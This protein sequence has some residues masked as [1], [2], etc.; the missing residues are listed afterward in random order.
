MSSPR[1]PDV[2]PKA[3]FER[4][5]AMVYRRA[6]QLLGSHEDAEEAT[7]EVFIRV[8]RSGDGFEGK[9]RVTTWLYE[10]TTNYC[11]NQLR[12]RARRAELWQANGPTGDAPTGAGADD[13][14]AARQLLAR[15]EPQQALAAVYVFIDGMSHE[16][17]AARL[18]VSKRTVGNLVERFR[19]WVA[20]ESDGGEALPA[21]RTY[22]SK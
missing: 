19:A 9:S 15:A 18:G 12:N 8:L 4:H 13:F 2:D 6:R 5:G 22:G 16:E 21:A 1:H 7:Q 10:V 11:L 17:A 3:L 14:A 20:A